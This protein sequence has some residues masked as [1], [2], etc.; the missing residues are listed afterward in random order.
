MD[1]LSDCAATAAVLAA[2]LIGHF[3]SLQIDGWCGIVVAALVLWAGIQ[4]P[5]GHHL[6]PARSAARAG[7]CPED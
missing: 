5:R 3:T 7:I 1:S 6:S 4:G 2:T